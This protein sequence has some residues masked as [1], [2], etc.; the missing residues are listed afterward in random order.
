MRIVVIGGTGYVGRR[1]V[2]ALRRFPNVTVDVASRRG[3]LVVDVSRAD[4]FEGLRGADVVVDLSDGTRGAPD[5]L[6]TWC[7]ASG[8]TLLEATS[9][10]PTIARLRAALTGKPGPGRVVL[11]AGIFTGMSNLLARSVADAVGPGS[12]LT[13]GIASSPYSGAGKAT[14][15]LMV[16]AAARPAVRTVDGARRE[17]PLE[18]GPV[19]DFPGLRRPTLR[20]S[21]AEAEMLPHST[22]A[23]AVDTLFAPRPGFLVTAFA[24][25]PASLVQR[26]WFQRLLE[27]YFTLLR[28]VVLRAVPSAVELVAF[29][30][31]AGQRAARS[32]R[33][34]DG[35]DACAWAIAAL[36]EAVGRAP[37]ALGLSFIDDA[38]QLEPTVTRI[39]E[40]AGRTV[41]ALE[42]QVSASSPAPS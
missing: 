36:A 42:P 6:A 34:R 35:M 4:T 16:D 2:E 18:R 23:S 10:A 22:R 33:A 20:M 13:L 28:R 31:R 21:L 40:V 29:A 24:A 37:P 17:G 30:E 8:L 41:Y 14:I 32:V 38:A 27:G 3:P 39:N 15:A 5:A 9:D 1:T 11:G 12:A 25:L 7:L 19:L 26:R